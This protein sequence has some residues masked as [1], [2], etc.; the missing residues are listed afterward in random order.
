ML[1]LTFLLGKYPTNLLFLANT[2]SKLLEI[3]RT[4]VKLSFKQVP[5]LFVHAWSSCVFHVAAST[6]YQLQI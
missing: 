6:Y 2:V 3:F 4:G 5:F 1:F